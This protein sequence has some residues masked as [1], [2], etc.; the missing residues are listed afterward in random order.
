MPPENTDPDLQDQE[1]ETT[2]SE[3]EAAVPLVPNA[4]SSFQALTEEQQREGGF[5]GRM[6]AKLQ[7]A[8][9]TG[10]A[11]NRTRSAIDDADGDPRITADDIAIRRA[12]TVSAQKMVVPEGVI[13]SGS[14]TS[15]SETEISGRIDGDVV[16]DGRLYLGPSALVSGNVRATSCRVEG[17]IEGRI[18]CSQDLELGQ[19]GRLNADALAGNRILVAGHVFGDVSSG[20]MVHIKET[21]E[22]SGDVRTKRFQVDEGATF[23]GICAM[24]SNTPRKEE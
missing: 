21:A 3:E 18:E 15:G 16:V 5:F 14:L 8:I 4:P 2:A 1:Q 12:K 23:N 9:Q 10:R 20:G 6:N 22:V 19:S 17:L 13:I 11:P 24:R 7:D